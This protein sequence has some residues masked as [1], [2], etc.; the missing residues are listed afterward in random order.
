MIGFS[1]FLLIG[2]VV[3]LLVGF[4]FVAGG[5]YFSSR[6]GQ[7]NRLAILT[8][9]ILPA[10]LVN[11]WWIFLTLYVFFQLFVLRRDP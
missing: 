11:S 1:F 10:L 8:L 6:S 2:I 4:L 9:G 5:V 7:T 3:S